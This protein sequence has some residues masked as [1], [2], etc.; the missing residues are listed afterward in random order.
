[1]SSRATMMS[2]RLVITSSAPAPWLASR[3]DAAKGGHR[4][5]G[6]DEQPVIP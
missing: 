6:L 3:K 2:R 5:S 4:H 1:M